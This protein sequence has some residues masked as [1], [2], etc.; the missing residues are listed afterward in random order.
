MPH[1]EYRVNE[2]AQETD[3]QTLT[4]RQILKHAEIDPEL[5]FLVENHPEHVSYQDRP[6]ESIHMVP[7]MRFITEHQ[8]IEYKVNDEDQTTKHRELRAN[9]ILTLAGIDSTANYL[10]EIFP[11][12]ESF[13]GKGEEKI[14]MHQHMKFISVSIKPTPVSE[15]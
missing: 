5:H 8:L 7:H 14:H 4:A 10:S 15:H 6:D 11:E 12:H 9:E 1:I 3:H 13:E 2:V